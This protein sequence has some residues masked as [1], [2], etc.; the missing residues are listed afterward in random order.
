MN[1]VLRWIFFVPIACLSATGVYWVFMLLRN[2]YY[3]EIEELGYEWL[4]NV[5]SNG[6][7]A[8]GVA[9]YFAIFIIVSVSIA[10]S[11]KDKVNIFISC[12]LGLSPIIYAILGFL[13]IITIDFALVQIISAVGILIGYYH[14][15]WVLEKEI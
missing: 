12:L 6:I 2:A 7:H 14:E 10:P 1:K 4:T 15:K 5:F 8:I 11:H 3:K 13:K 9:A